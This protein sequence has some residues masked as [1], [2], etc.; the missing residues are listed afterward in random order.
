M[1]QG[2]HPRSAF[3]PDFL[4]DKLSASSP[5]NWE[6]GDLVFAIIAGAVMALIVFG[7]P[8]AIIGLFTASILDRRNGKAIEGHQKSILADLGRSFPVE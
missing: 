4:L 5:E 2:R 7:L 1:P 3:V 6:L 8:L